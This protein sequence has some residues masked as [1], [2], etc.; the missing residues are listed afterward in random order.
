MSEEEEEEVVYEEVAEPHVIETG[1]SVKVKQVFDDSLIDAIVKYGYE[2]NYSSEN[3]KI[4]LMLL[5][6]IFA[7][8]AQFYPIPFPQS[9]PLLGVC[10]AAYF[11]LSSILQFIITFIDKDIVMKTKVHKGKGI[12][13]LVRASFPRFQE[14]YTV[15]IQEIDKPKS[16]VTTGKLYVGK[17]FTSKGEFDEEGFQRDVQLHVER[18]EQKKY[19]DFEYNHKTD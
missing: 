11:I 8:T 19:I 15:I 4:L 9:R 18:F 13:L 10:C 12:G 16:P 2:A 14:Y 5:S 3:L 17:Y 7:M 6:C 1:D